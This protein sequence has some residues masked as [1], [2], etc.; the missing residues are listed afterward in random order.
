MKIRWQQHVLM[1]LETMKISLFTCKYA[2][3]NRPKYFRNADVQTLSMMRRRSDHVTHELNGRKARQKLN[4]CP[5]M[6]V[7]GR[8]RGVVGWE[9]GANN[10]NN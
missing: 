9:G 10:G 2:D 4:L 3:T 6:G 8:G 7:W 1:G 5:L